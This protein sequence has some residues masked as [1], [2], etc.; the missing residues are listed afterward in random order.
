MRLARWR[1]TFGKVVGGCSILHPQPWD[2]FGHHTPNFLWIICL[3]LMWSEWSGR[4]GGE[5]ARERARV[6][7]VELNELGKSGKLGPTTVQ[8]E[9]CCRRGVPCV[10][11]HY[12]GV[13][14]LPLE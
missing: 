5:E 3:T 13:H 11:G 7:L 12:L 8:R 4:R 2:H 14:Y 6:H 9:S 1:K 10:H